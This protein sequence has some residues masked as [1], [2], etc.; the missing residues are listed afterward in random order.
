MMFS[1][2]SR[3]IEMQ[4]NVLKELPTRIDKDK[5]KTYAQLDERFEFAELT[6][7]ISVF[8]KGMRMMKN[9]LVGV[10]CLD[11]KKML[12]DGIRI[13]LVQHIA[14]TLHTILTFSPKPKQD[15]L[16]QKL[17]QLVQIMDGYK[18]SFEYIQC[19]VCGV[20][21]EVALTLKFMHFYTNYSKDSQ[22]FYAE[23]VPKEILH[24]QQTLSSS[25]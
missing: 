5:I 22:E 9:T 20:P 7:S 1:K 10:V 23:S 16:D 11:P 8:S 12:E 21:P 15:D 18:R 25:H 17:K 4:T 13:E 2:F 19:K 24:L 6:N 14:K 3:I